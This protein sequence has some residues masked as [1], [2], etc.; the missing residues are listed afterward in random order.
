MNFIAIETPLPPI[1]YQ[2]EAYLFSPLLRLTLLPHPAF[3]SPIVSLS[4]PTLLTTPPTFS[5]FSPTSQHHSPPPSHFI[6]SRWLGSSA[7]YSCIPPLATARGRA[8]LGLRNTPN[9]SHLLTVSPSLPRALPGATA[10]R[11]LKNTSVSFFAFSRCPNFLT[12]P[13]VL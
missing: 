13:S 8:P 7:G 12:V 1:K 2:R 3:L 4:P 9:I 5:P 11:R 6:F 10:Y